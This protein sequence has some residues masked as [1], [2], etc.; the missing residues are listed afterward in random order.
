[1]RT[2]ATTMLAILAAAANAT[3]PVFPPMPAKS[4]S[5]EAAVSA[6]RDVAAPYSVVHFTGGYDYAPFGVGHLK[7]DDASA[8]YYDWASKIVLPIWRQPRGVASAFV[9]SGMLWQYDMGLVVPLSGAG[10]VET[11]YEHQSLIVMHRTADGW[12]QIRVLP[13]PEGVVWTHLCHLGLGA[14]KLAYE[15]WE[16]Y[17]TE[18]GDWLHFRAR[19]PHA[20]RGE[21]AMAAPRLT[22]IG[23]DHELERLETRGEWL[24]VR[25]RQPAWTCA[26]PDRLFDGRVDE[27]WVKWQDAV[28]GPWVWPFTRGC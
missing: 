20:L 23:L 10:M 14:A 7:V 25:V 15:G 2:V 8:H 22:W 12:V 6:W 19:V 3:C 17:I 13:A 27:G 24:R 26:G 16:T 18:H 21:P 1:M 5:E 4:V 9:R 28:S 11:E